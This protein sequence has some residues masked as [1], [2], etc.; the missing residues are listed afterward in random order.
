M[1]S[2]LARAALAEN[3]TIPTLPS[4]VSR[5]NAL[6]ADENSGLRD[7]GREIAQD[8]PISS[9]MLRLANSAVYGT[10]ERVLSAEHAAS[11]LG[12][13]VVRNLVMQSAVI[14]QFNHLK[15]VR[16]FDFDGLWRHA[17]ASALIARQLTRITPVPL[18]WEPEEAYTCA[19]LHDVGK[20][21]LL[22]GA[23]EPYA[24]LIQSAASSGRPLFSLEREIIG[25]DHAEVGARVL[26]HWGLDASL[27]TVVR[28]HHAPKTTLLRYPT[29]C[30]MALAEQTAT[31]VALQAADEARDGLSGALGKALNI[32]SDQ[33]QTL[34]EYAFEV[35]T[36]IVV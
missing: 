9:K 17:I 7:V 23:P 32:P 8:A 16:G 4:V 29:L 27:I 19:L 36:E 34:V 20:I 1:H 22:D 24:A 18:E 12:M 26:E 25:L 15:S 5:I 28:N 6:L 35:Y 33:V 14:E 30:L 13:R 10:R 31:R 11:V 21:V 3:V 2:D